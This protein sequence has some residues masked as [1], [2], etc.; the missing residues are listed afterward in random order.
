MQT[1]HR[2]A[3][4]IA[5][6]STEGAPSTNSAPCGNRTHDLLAVRRQC[7]HRATVTHTDTHTHTQ[8][9]TYHTL[10]HTQ[11]QTYHTNNTHSHT[12]TNTDIPHTQ[13]QTYHI[14]T[15]TH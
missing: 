10:T 4:E 14:H 3:R 13:I 7:K 6:L 12:H 11:I 5:H 1:T 15:H 8:I 2:T 9:Q